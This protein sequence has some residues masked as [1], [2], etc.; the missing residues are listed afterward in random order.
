METL[1]A[2]MKDGDYLR[3]SKNKPKIYESKEKAK[4]VLEKYSGWIV[5]LS[6]QKYSELVL[7]NKFVRVGDKQ[8][9]VFE[10]DDCGNELAVTNN[11]LYC[12][13]CGSKFL[14]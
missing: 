12:P 11:V 10:C 3:D 13:V 2:I 7:T 14:K 6:E 9:S 1:Y 8:V 5:E 4:K